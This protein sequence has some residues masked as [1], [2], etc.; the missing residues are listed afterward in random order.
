MFF[1]LKDIISSGIYTAFTKTFDQFFIRVFN[2]ESLKLQEE[3]QN[4]LK[5][6]EF[7]KPY[8]LAPYED[9]GFWQKAARQIN[10]I[11]Y[12]V[13][14]FNHGLAHSLRQGALSKDILKILMKMKTEYETLDHPELN[15]LAL[16]ICAKSA[17]EK[18]FFH[19]V[20]FAASFQRS[21]RQSEGSSSADIEKYKRY[22]KQDAINFH[23]AA[24]TSNLFKDQQ[25]IKIFEE[26]ILWENKGTLSEE[27]NPDLKYLRRILHTAH[28]FDLRR[29]PSFNA[30]RIRKDGIKQLLGMLEPFQETVHCRQ[31]QNAIWDRIGEYLD[32]TGDRDLT[33][34]SI[35]GDN[36]FYQTVNPIKMVDAICQMRESKIPI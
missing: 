14:R 23:K 31:I 34:K 8:F 33:H 12:I 3:K 36:F 15:D 17:S 24:S 6:M 22:E 20:E 5:I 28:T 4:T 25:E 10:G 2:H 18:D 30:E 29:M 7:V 9:G 16:W 19:K 35:L 32:A 13:N 27:L 26:A 11:E 1:Y 21:G